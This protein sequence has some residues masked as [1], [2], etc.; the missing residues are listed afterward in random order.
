[1]MFHATF[2]QKFRIFNVG[3]TK[4]VSGTNVLLNLRSPGRTHNTFHVFF[5][6][7]FLLY[8]MSDLTGIL[9]IM[10]GFR[11][12]KV[13]FAAVNMGVFDALAQQP[14]GLT[15]D[16][17]A[18]SLPGY[19]F[20]TTDGLSRLLR[21]C[22]SLSLLSID[23]QQQRFSLTSESS[24][25]LVSS[26]RQS[27]AGYIKYCN[28][29]IYPLWSNLEASVETGATCWTETFG[30][31]DGSDPK[32]VFEHIYNGVDGSRRFMRAMDGAVD[33]TAPTI[34]QMVPLDWVTG[35]LDIGGSTGRFS[36][37]ICDALPNCKQ[38]IVFELPNIVD[39]AEDMRKE[40]QINERVVYQK[41]NFLDVLPELPENIN[42]VLLSRILHD[43]NDQTSLELLKSTHAALTATKN[44]AAGIV[45]CDLLFDDDSKVS[46]VDANLQ[47]L[48]MMVQTV[49][50]TV[51][52]GTNEK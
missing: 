42:A 10:S 3:A 16:E 12:S 25:Y 4:H 28:A 43:W 21:G 1:M 35:I 20:Q 15:V 33:N 31:V 18:L 2:Y 22:V 36:S 41:G 11:R 44:K 38:A 29:V 52:L 48:N 5:P 51:I 46:P 14:G 13:M 34:L 9:D 8:T 17:L 6:F 27:L 24:R 23:K 37:Y 19:N 7:P 26:S 45:I 39:L 50:C 49:S 40:D 32:K 47:D 30:Y